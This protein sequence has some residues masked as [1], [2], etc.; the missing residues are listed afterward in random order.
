MK[1]GSMGMSCNSLTFRCC[2]TIILEEEV[3]EE[4]KEHLPITDLF[5]EQ[6]STEI[7]EAD[8]GPPS[9][10]DEKKQPLLKVFPNPVQAELTISGLIGIEQLMVLDLSGKLLKQI[11]IQEVPSVSLN[12]ESF[13]AGVYL[14]KFEKEGKPQVQRF[15]KH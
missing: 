9:F 13:M 7:A 10:I 11:S 3:E 4:E 6:D 5:A 2:R 8:A 1:E 12:V 15:I 14:I